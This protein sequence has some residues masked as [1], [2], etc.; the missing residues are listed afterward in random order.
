MTIV[1]LWTIAGGVGLAASLFNVLDARKDKQA[2]EAL[3]RDG[4]ARSAARFL[5]RTELVRL[6]QLVLITAIGAIA[7]LQPHLPEGWAEVEGFLIRWGLVAIAVALM[8][9]S[10]QSFFYRRTIRKEVGVP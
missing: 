1:W 8:A 2:L 7:L 5:Q 9:N 6:F 3:N 4:L 10:A